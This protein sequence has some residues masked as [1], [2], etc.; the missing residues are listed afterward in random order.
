MLWGGRSTASKYH[1]RVCTVIQPH[2]VCPHPRRVCF[3]SLHCSGSRL[4]RRELSEAGPGLQALSRS[5]PLRFRVSGPPQRCR[6]GWACVL[7]PSQV[8]AVQV[9]RCLAS[10]VA[11]SWGCSL[12]PPPSQSLGFLGVQRASVPCAVCLF[13]EADLWLRPSR[14]MS[15]VQSPKKS[16]LAEKSVCS[17]TQD[18]S[19]GPSAPFRLWLPS[20]A[21][22][23]WEMGRSAASQLCSV[24]CSVS[25]PGGMLG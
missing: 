2:W 24:L 18:A 21:C 10:A 15:I 25:V 16:C 11:P 17:F 9:S 23:G 19:L 5:K 4:L 22:L 12:S 3:P 14:W 6:P 13:W 1:W 7:C 20:P 8:L